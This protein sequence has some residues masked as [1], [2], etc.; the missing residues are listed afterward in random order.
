M[1]TNV[2]SAEAEVVAKFIN[3]QEA[4]LKLFV[5]ATGFKGS[6]PQ[7]S[8]YMSVIAHHRKYRLI[9]TPGAVILQANIEGKMCEVRRVHKCLNGDFITSHIPRQQLET[10]ITVLLAQLRTQF[11]IR[12]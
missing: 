2:T 12:P 11:R 8:S 9:D 10:I 7:P 6:Q 3:K 5:S 1:K 4:A